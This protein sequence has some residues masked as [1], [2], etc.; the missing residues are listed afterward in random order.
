MFFRSFFKW[1]YIVRFFLFVFFFWRE[2]FEIY[3]VITFVIFLG[4]RFFLV[5]REFC[6]VRILFYSFSC[7]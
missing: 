4:V 3:F 7:F 6:V 1:N 2:D 5:G